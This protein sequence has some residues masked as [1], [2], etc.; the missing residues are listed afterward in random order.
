MSLMYER[1]MEK[2]AE[3]RAEEESAESFDIINDIK[4]SIGKD[5][6]L[7]ELYENI[8]ASVINYTNLVISQEKKR[9]VGGEPLDPRVTEDSDLFRKTSHDA[10]IDRLNILSRRMVEKG[11]EPKWRMSWGPLETLTERQAISRWAERMAP[12]FEKEK[13]EVEQKAKLK[14]KKR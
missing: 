11:I 12:V 7:K 3:E 10:L 9:G 2:K 13:E 4:K 5:K 6:E 8:K 1:E 14:N